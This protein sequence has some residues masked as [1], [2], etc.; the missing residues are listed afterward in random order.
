MHKEKAKSEK[1]AL[2]QVLKSLSGKK[3]HSS[4]NKHG[5]RSSQKLQ[6]NAKIHLT[7]HKVENRP[8]EGKITERKKSKVSVVHKAQKHQK[9]NKVDSLRKDLNKTDDFYI[10]ENDEP[11]EKLHEVEVMD[12]EEGKEIADPGKE[13]IKKRT[14]RGTVEAEAGPSYR[15]GPSRHLLQFDSTIPASDFIPG[16]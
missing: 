10:V 4:G 7:H 3:E 11:K 6:V 2:N 5:S 14:Q 16:L 12:I 13:Q 15:R 1:E 8:L 9:P